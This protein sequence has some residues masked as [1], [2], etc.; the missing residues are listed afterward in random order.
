MA[1]LIA[2]LCHWTIGHVRGNALQHSDQGQ[3]QV[4]GGDTKV[5]QHDVKTNF[6]HNA[7]LKLYRSAGS[8]KHNNFMK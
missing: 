1:S 3:N 5:T 8:V 7:K 2:K 6:S 4:H